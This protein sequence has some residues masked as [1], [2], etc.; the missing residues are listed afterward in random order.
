MARTKLH[1][2]HV[3]LENTCMIDA[4]QADATVET[5]TFDKLC[6]RG[7]NSRHFLFSHFSDKN[8][9]TD[10]IPYHCGV[11]RAGVWLGV[12]RGGSVREDEVLLEE[13]EGEA[14]GLL[15]DRDP[16]AL[17]P[18]QVVVL[19]QHLKSKCQQH[20]IYVCFV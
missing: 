13:E 10:C 8:N 6:G 5:E 3:G 16:L 2:A 1:S 11:Q 15:V 17:V 19:H 7:C 9:R 18:V 20:E 12:G 14:V 4:C